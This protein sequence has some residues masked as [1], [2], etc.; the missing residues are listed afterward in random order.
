[1]FNVYNSKLSLNLTS[2]TKLSF[3]KKT[4]GDEGMGIILKKILVSVSK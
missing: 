3:K 1:M 4:G 2:L